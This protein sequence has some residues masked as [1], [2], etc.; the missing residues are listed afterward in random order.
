M[1]EPTETFFSKPTIGFFLN[2]LLFQFPF[3]VKKSLKGHFTVETITK[4]LPAP[5]S[6][7]S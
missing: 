4:L 6:V 1:L 7:K 5:V 2:F 3:Y